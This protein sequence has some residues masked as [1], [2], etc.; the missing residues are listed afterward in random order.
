M[1]SVISRDQADES[2]KAEAL[3]WDIAG[4]DRMMGVCA[5]GGGKGRKDEPSRG[6]VCMQNQLN[7]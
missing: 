7:H 2:S 6:T 3:N 4:D 5:C 1:E